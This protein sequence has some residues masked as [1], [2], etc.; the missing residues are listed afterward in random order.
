MK[1]QKFSLKNRLRS[2]KYAFN[3]LRIMIREEHN[4]WIHIFVS[5]CVL[6]AGFLLKITTYEWIAVIFCIGFVMALELINSAIENMADFVSPERH[7][8]IK[9]I[10]DLSAGAVL[11]GA[12][13]SAII[14]LII[15]LPKI[16]VLCN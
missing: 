4:S 13:I 7:A 5:L 15:F 9:K 10:K 11:I 2:F 8:M 14:G 3:G 12:I 16:V 1:Q 6:I